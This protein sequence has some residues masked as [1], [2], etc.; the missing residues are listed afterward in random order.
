[1]NFSMEA[2]VRKFQPDRYEKWLIGRDFGRHP[3]SCEGEP[4]TT[5][6]APSLE[7]LTCVKK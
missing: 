1:M 4:L 2:F 6:P 3:L 7:D 5:A